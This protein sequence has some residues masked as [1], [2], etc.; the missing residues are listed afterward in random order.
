MS[1]LNAGT[2][3]GRIKLIGSATLSLGGV[4]IVNTTF[5]TSTC[6]IYLTA[7]EGITN[8]GDVSV[9]AIIYDVRFTIG[10]TNVLD[11]RVVDYIIIEP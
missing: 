1:W 6:K 4:V 2:P 8:V 5:A 11:R 9:T 10:S 7:R 3:D